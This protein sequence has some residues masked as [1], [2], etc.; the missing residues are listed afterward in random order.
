MIHPTFVSET[1]ET[2]IS[3]EGSDIALDCKVLGNPKP[4]IKWRAKDELIKSDQQVL[5]IKNLTFDHMGSYKCEASNKFGGPISKSFFVFLN[6]SPKSYVSLAPSYS[7][8]Q[9]EG[10][11]VKCMAIGEP[12]PALTLTKN[13]H[14]VKNTIESSKPVRG[15][16]LT[17]YS[18]SLNLSSISFE[19]DLGT[20]TCEARN[21]LG[22]H[23]SSLE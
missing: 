21:E 11:Q 22:V 20:Y 1:T 14:L 16:N 3:E 23:K 13:G 15:L 19:R 6:F 12:Q 17:E 18:I 10:L 5:E 4:S 7:G 8:S 9:L 2:I